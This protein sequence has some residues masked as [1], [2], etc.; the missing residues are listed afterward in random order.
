LGHDF[1]FVH[2]PFDSESF[3]VDSGGGP[4]LAK[5]TVME[6]LKVRR[7]YH[8]VSFVVSPPNA[9]LHFFPLN[10]IARNSSASGRVVLDSLFKGTYRFVLKADAATYDSL[11]G[12]FSVP[13]DTMR[14]SLNRKNV[15]VRFVADRGLFPR[16]ILIPAH[17]KVS[18][19]S[20]VVTGRLESEELLR[21]GVGVE[22]NVE[23]EAIEDWDLAG[24]LYVGSRKILLSR[25]DAGK[26]VTI[27]VQEKGK[28]KPL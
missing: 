9:Q 24:R 1:T 7:R 14:L 17:F 3:E 27:K 12:E 8:R 10:R 25:N 21:L 23:A 26:S 20:S 28:P 11:G 16:T 19:G 2:H 6:T 22:Y 18:L 5:D 13:G 15:E 4:V